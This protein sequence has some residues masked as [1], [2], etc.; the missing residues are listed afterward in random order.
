[1]YK[2]NTFKHK[3]LEKHFMSFHQLKK[4]VGLN[5]FIHFSFLLEENGF[6]IEGEEKSS[7]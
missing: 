2:E 3:G 4:R 1:M 5:I 7:L 6:G